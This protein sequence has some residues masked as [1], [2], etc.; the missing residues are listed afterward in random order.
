MRIERC[1]IQ[2]SRRYRAH[3]LPNAVDVNSRIPLVGIDY[4]ESTPVPK[5]HVNLARSTLVITGN[6][7]AAALARELTGNIE[8]PLFSRAL[9]N[10]VAEF[11]VR[12]VFDVLDCMIIESYKLRRSHLFRQIQSKSAAGQRD[13]VRARRTGQLREQRA[14]KTDADDRDGVILTDV[15]AAKNIHRAAQG[16]AGKWPVVENLREFYCRRHIAYI[17][18]SVCVRGANGDAIGFLKV[19]NCTADFL[20]TA[21]RFVAECAGRHWI[22]KPRFAFPWRNV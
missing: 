19:A 11:A 12:E 7:E 17:V 21:P 20:Y 2:Q 15:A 10:N 9:D 22:C 4:V 13:H 6:N 16:F 3:C 1:R 5:L 8:R 18:V 14:K